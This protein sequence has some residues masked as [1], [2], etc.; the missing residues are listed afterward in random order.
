MK[1]VGI[2]TG[3]GDCPGL[4]AVI[5]SATIMLQKSGYKMLGIK[6]GWRGAVEGDA[7]EL[8]LRD[9]DEIL[10]EGGTVLGSSRT[11]PYKGAD[12]TKVTTEPPAA[13]QQILANAK[14]WGLE[15]LIAIGGDDT[16]EVA[17]YL[18]KYHGLKTVGCPKTI[19]NDVCGTDV[20]FGF[21]TAVEVAMQ[22]IDRL[23]TTTRSHGRVMVIECM[24]RHAGWITCYAGMASNADYV[25]VPE[26]P[27]E[28]EEIA[29]TIV[30][31]RKRG[32]NYNMIVIAEG[33]VI[34]GVNDKESLRKKGERQKKIDSVILQAGL[35]DPEKREKRDAFGNLVI[36]PGDLAEQLAEKLEQETKF[37]TRFI[38]LGHIQ[39]GGSPTAYD[40]ILGTRYGLEA[41]RLVLKGE[42]GRMV[43]LKGTDITSLPFEGNLRPDQTSKK[44]YKLLP[45]G[46]LDDATIFFGQ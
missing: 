23:R 34:N 28:F 26:R 35:T 44:Q 15:A 45:L 38:A 30:E 43:V 41:A 32:K 40:R 37:E 24:G 39:R 29:Q 14:K 21:M 22:E 31:S 5:R 17:Y 3:G 46:L 36:Q 6:D 9:V 18:N 20:T 13:V 2:L 16:L 1:T 8:Q 10:A 4:N 27:C 11:N 42:F 7:R 12:F 25:A 19:D 33:A